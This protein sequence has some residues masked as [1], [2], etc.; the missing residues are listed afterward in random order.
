[1]LL[2]VLLSVMLMGAEPF[3]ESCWSLEVCCPLEISRLVEFD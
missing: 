2:S 3:A 1:L